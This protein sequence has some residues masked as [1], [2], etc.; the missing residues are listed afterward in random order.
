MS[1]MADETQDF[2]EAVR[3]YVETDAPANAIGTIDPAYTS[4]RPRVLF[5]GETV[6]GGKTY[7]YLA[8]YTPVASHRV[9]LAPV[10]TGFVVLGR[11]V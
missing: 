2:L 8:S 11:I 9:L 4:G 3:G 1:L 7:P 6:L 5:D 10:G